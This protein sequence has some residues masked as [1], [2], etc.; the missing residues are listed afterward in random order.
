M[1]V[2]FFLTTS[3]H[4][5]MREKLKQISQF[6]YWDFL[7]LIFNA[8]LTTFFMQYLLLGKYEI[9]VMK[10][11]VWLLNILGV[12]ICHLVVFAIFLNTKFTCIMVQLVGLIS[13]LTN[14]FVIQFRGSEVSLNDIKSLST[15]ITVVKGYHFTVE[16]RLYL[17]AIAVGLYV[18]ILLV[19]I[20]HKLKHDIKLRLEIAFFTLISTIVFCWG[21]KDIEI[22]LWQNQGSRY[23]GFLVNFCVGIREG[24]LSKPK[25]YSSN[26]A[27]E[28]LE[29]FSTKNL[30]NE[31]KPIII[32]VMN[33]SFAD[34]SVL[35]EIDTNSSVCPF[36]DSLS[37]NTIKGYALSSV[38]GGNTPNSE[39]EFLTGNTMAFLPSGSV[40]YEQYIKEN[41]SSLIRFFE[42]MDYITV[43]MHPYYAKGWNRNDVYPSLGFDETVFI[44]DFNQDMLLREFIT[45]E[46]LYNKIIERFE[47]LDQ[48]ENLFV[49][50]ITMQNHGGYD[51]PFE[52]FDEKI[53]LNNYEY[54]DV[55]RY[56]SLIHES[57]TAL[58]KLISYFNNV[59]RP[60]EIVFFGDHQPRLNNS[61]LESLLRQKKEEWDLDTLQKTYEIPFFVWTNY[62][63]EEE[64]VEMCS[65]NYIPTIMLEKSGLNYPNY[66][67]F[68]ETCRKVIPSV[69]A[70]GYYSLENHKYIS[71]N[72]ASGTEKKWLDDYR[73][74]QYYDMF[75][76]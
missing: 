66:F 72:E 18:V 38:Y 57:D 10:W 55:N 25:N 22:R 41:P 76:K 32:V 30:E 45:D 54:E 63:I 73:I 1:Y 70:N 42:N 47:A 23:N 65:I 6:Q 24:H 50:A 59:D 46:S 71:I 13:S 27:E 69:N 9:Q 20:K 43:A 40:V 53:Q 19:F 62:D 48:D 21:I 68:L 39:W 8:V 56:L 37:D 2:V 16:N 58:E 36:Y 14:Y 34:L 33:E 64:N 35:G 15:G 29:Q 75:K 3:Y 7:L 17:V 12:L 26:L 11:Y 44:E 51:K 4:L 49:M 52:N 74:L 60:V 5:Q 61:F 28:K 67:K 31:E